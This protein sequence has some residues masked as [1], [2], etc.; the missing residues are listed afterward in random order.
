M[1]SY[2][3]GTI[4]NATWCPWN[5]FRT[6]GD[7]TNNWNSF[8]RNLQTTTQYQDYNEPLAKPVRREG[9][10]R[11]KEVASAIVW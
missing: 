8:F 11:N 3:Q 10:Q 4:P 1:P 2:T 9:C 6:S 7:I 5:F